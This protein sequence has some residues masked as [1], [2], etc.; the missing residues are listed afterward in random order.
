[1]AFTDVMKKVF[2]FIS[3]AASLGGPLGIMAAG[4]VGKAL[5]VDKVPN[6]QTGIANT[7]AAAMAD[8]AQRAALIKAEQ[9]FQVQMA[10]LGFKDK[11]SLA[12]IDAGDR[13]DAR[14]RQV[15]LK[16]RVPAVLAGAVTLGFFLTLTLMFFHAIPDA[17]HDVLLVMIGALGT[18][19]TQV[20]SYYYGSSSGS[21]RKSEILGSIAGNG[22]H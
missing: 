8:P 14:D 22:T 10:E 13:L 16:D 18:A 7:I 12:A 1:M 15:K 5:G 17:G 6:D 3:A 2:P 19:W 20:I 11:E 21:D 4:V 9:D